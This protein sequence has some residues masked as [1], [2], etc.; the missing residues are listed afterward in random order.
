MRKTMEISAIALVL[1]ISAISCSSVPPGTAINQ[2]GIESAVKFQYYLDG[3]LRLVLDRQK[4]KIPDTSFKVVAGHVFYTEEQILIKNKTRGVAL[5][6]ERDKEGYAIL[7]MAFTNDDT[8]TIRFRQEALDDPS[9]SFKIMIDDT[10]NG[11]KTIKYGEAYYT[12]GSSK[13]TL[14]EIIVSKLLKKKV[15]TGDNPELLIKE[16]VWVKSTING[17]PGRFVILGDA[18]KT[19]PDGAK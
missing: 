19:T 1:M 17:M 2:V 9:S 16:T 8:K 3:D 14:Y 6:S 5:K 11:I 7:T 15:G 13:K 12:I 10:S 4:S 18:A